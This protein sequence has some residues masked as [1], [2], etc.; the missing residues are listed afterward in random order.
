MVIIA[1]GMVL[2]TKV[3]LAAAVGEF[4]YGYS[5][6]NHCYCGEARARAT[7][8]WFGSAQCSTVFRLT[9]S[10]QIS[11]R[12]LDLWCDVPDGI[13]DILHSLVQYES[14]GSR[15]SAM[16]KLVAQILDIK[17]HL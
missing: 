3:A 4:I 6:S 16:S 17:K 1:H 13:D 15:T 10:G 5:I 7:F 8:A 12:G 14:A 11:L 2:K 9:R